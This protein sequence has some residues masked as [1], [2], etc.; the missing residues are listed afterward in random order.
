MGFSM[1]PSHNKTKLKSTV[2][3]GSLKHDDFLFHTGHMT[4]TIRKGVM[5]SVLMVPSH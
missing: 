1:R 2:Q 3:E 5:G 4:E